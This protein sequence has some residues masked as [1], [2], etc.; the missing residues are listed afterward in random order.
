VLFSLV[1][2]SDGTADQAAANNVVDGVIDEVAETQ[3]L[4]AGFRPVF[5]LDT[6]A[7]AR[8]RSYGYVAELVTPRIAWVGEPAAWSSYLGARVASMTVTY[9]VSTMI[10]IGPNGLDDV[11]RG[12]LR[13]FR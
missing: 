13:A 5:L 7:F 4:A 3:L 10:T 1:G 11:A 12:V 9:G 2:L 6:P 8:A